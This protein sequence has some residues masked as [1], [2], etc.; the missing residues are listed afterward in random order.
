MLR[1]QA[2][3][4]TGFLLLSGGAQ[5]SALSAADILADFNI[6][7]LGNLTSTSEV[8]GRTLVEGNLS[9][10][11][12]TYFTRGNQISPVSGIAALTVGGNVQQSGYINVNNS[13]TLAVGGSA[14]NVNMNGGTGKVA[15][16][17]SGNNNGNAIQSG[18]SVS[19]PSVASQVSSL[20]SALMGLTSNS[21]YT[22]GS[23]TLTL[24][25]APNASGV[26]VF[27]IANA[28]AVFSAVNQVSINLNGATSVI[29]NVGGA[30]ATLA[31][32]FLAGSA[33][34]AA[35]KLLWNFY[36][37][38]ALTVSAEFGGTVL[39]PLANVTTSAS[40]DGTLIANNVTQN[41]EMHQ[42]A[43]S[44][45][46]PVASSGASGAAAAVP[47]PAPLT[48]ALAGALLLW[49]RARFIRRSVAGVPLH[50]G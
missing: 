48:L 42:Y 19:I 18:A 10:S 3:L 40:I 25:A 34:S 33:Q 32:N 13:G 23:N 35:T 36:E 37:A 30:S 28:A 43:Y 21:S 2:L 31:E 1:K 44:G 27:T 20:S 49:G 6:V 45:V 12:S 5:A 39:A 22:T 26:A 46:L 15:G 4:I 8:E 11:S 9:G 41:G 50:R 17:Y 24:N 38:T 7:T 29:I 16:S 14:V 47:E